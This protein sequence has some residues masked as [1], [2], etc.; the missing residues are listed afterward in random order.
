MVDILPD[1]RSGLDR[2]ST[3]S[4]CDTQARLTDVIGFGVRKIFFF[5]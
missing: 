5:S 3:V 4:A 1:P 2:V